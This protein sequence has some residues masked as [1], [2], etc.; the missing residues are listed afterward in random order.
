MT[1]ALNR[2]LIS[3]KGL[4]ATD[5]ESL[6]ERTEAYAGLPEDQAEFAA[7]NDLIAEATAERDEILGAIATQHADVVGKVSKKIDS[8]KAKQ[9]AE[10]KPD[11]SMIGDFGEKLEGA[12][13]DMAAEYKKHFSDDDIAKLPLSKIWPKQDIEKIED[14]FVAAVA[15]ATR[16]AVP[17]KPRTSYAVAAWVKKVKIA[18]SLAGMVLDGTVT[19]DNF[20]AKLAEIP[21]LKNFYSKVTLLESIDRAQWKRIGEVAE[22]P[23]A[24]WY[25][26]SNN[27]I[28]S[29]TV[30]VSIDGKSIS[31]KD[32]LSVADVI[33]KVNEALG[34]E[35]ED[36]KMQFE[37]RGR[38]GSYGINK[39]GDKEYRKLKTFAT[40]KEAFAFIKDNYTDLVAAW[41]GV[42][43]K[44]NVKKSD[45]RGATNRPRTGADHR[46]GKDVTAEEFQEAFGFRGGQF[47]NWVKQG[48]NAKDRQWMLNNAYDAL[49]DLAN[50]VG[51]P[52]KAISLNGSLGMSFGARG[53]GSASAHFEPGNLIINLTK[54]K[55]AGSLAHEWF[56]ALDN[57]FQRKRKDSVSFD[58]KNNFITYSPEA[59]YENPKGTRIPAK[60]F[61]AAKRG[62]KGLYVRNFDEWTKVEG[63]R[64]QVEA[65][66]DAL[67]K[68]LNDSPMTKR[69]AMIDAGK[70][71][72]YWSRIVERAARSFE[73][74]TIAKM[75]EQGYHNDYLA[76]VT[77]PARFARDMGRYPY[78]LP[79][80]IAPVSEAFDS[81]FG[82]METKETDKGV[83]LY[84]LKP[85]FAKGVSVQSVKEVAEPLLFGLRNAPKLE[86]VW[87]PADL[88]KHGI[89]APTGVRGVYNKGTLYIV[90]G[91]MSTPADVREVTFHEL[92]HFG[93]RGFFGKSLDKALDDIHAANPR[94]RMMATKWRR[95]NTDLIADLKTEHKL[96]DEDIHSISIDEALAEIAQTGETLK[97]W[98]KFVAALQ[99]LLRNVGLTRIANALESATDAEALLMLK[100]ADLYAKKGWTSKD[101]MPDAAYAMFQI[102]HAPPVFYSQ[103][104]R[105]IESHKIN[106]M[107]GKGWSDWLKSSS[108]QQMGVKKEEIE[109]TGINEWLSLQ[110]GK[111]TK[112]QI[113]AYL[114][115]GGVKVDEV[116][117]GEGDWAVYDGDSNQYFA[118]QSE[119]NA[120]AKEIGIN[121]TEDTVF[122]ATNRAGGYGTKFSSYVLPGGENYKELLLTLPDNYKSREQ[123]EQAASDYRKELKAKYGDIQLLRPDSPITA[124]E[125]AKLISLSDAIDNHL[126]SN[127]NFR[128]SHF[129]QPNIL[130]HIRMNER[131][132]AD[133]NK[134]LFIEEIQSDWGQK[135]KKEGFNSKVNL[136]AKEF[137]PGMFDIYEG[138]VVKNYQGPIEAK[139]SEEAIS[140]Y[141]ATAGTN[142]GHG[143]VPNAPFVTDTKSWTSLALKRAISYAVENGFQKIAWTTGEQQAA[144]YDLSKQVDALFYIKNGDGTFNIS[145]ER[146]NR[147]VLEE[148]NKTPSQL[149]EL[150]GKD[151][152]QKIVNDEGSGVED[153]KSISGAGL[154]VGGEG[155]KGF[156]DAIV[157][158]VAKKLGAEVGT[159]DLGSKLKR[160]IYVEKV[161]S[162]YILHDVING[163]YYNQ[164]Y[165]KPLWIDDKYSAMPFDSESEA[166]RVADKQQ[167]LPVE[168]PQPGF[169]ITD[170]MRE[171]VSRDGMPLFSRQ[172]T[173]GSV[174]DLK[175]STKFTDLIYKFQNKHIDLKDTIAAIKETGQEIRDTFNPYLQEELYH[176][177]VGKR[178]ED[179][180][181]NEFKP[182]L[183]QMRMNK[184]S[185]EDFEEYLHARH[186][187]EANK[188]IRDRDGMADGGS[189]MTDK[190]ADA[191]FAN[192][193]PA[194]QKTYES[195][196]AKVD[197]MIA[198]TRQTLVDYSLEDADTTKS[199]EQMFKHYVPLHREDMSEGQ[200]IGQGFSVKGKSTK[201][202]TGSSRQVADILANIA[203]QRDR[204]IVRGEKNRVATALY[205]LA[206]TNPNPD[207]WEADKVPT[208]QTVVKGKSTFDITYHGSVVRSVPTYAEAARFVKYDGRT[209]LQITEIKGKDHIESTSDP[210]Y[211]NR[212]NV[213]VARIRDSKGEVHDRAVVFNER[214][215]RALRMA[216]A[217]KNLD[218]PNLE[219]VI[220]LSAKVTRYLS[221]MSTQYNPVFV[222]VNFA[223]DFQNV[224]INLTSTP[225]AGKQLEVSKHAMSALIGIMA[226]LRAHRAGKTPNSVWAGLYEEMQLEGGTTGYREA[227]GTAKERTEDQIE[228]LLNPEWWAETGWGKALTV[229]GL[230]K[231]PEAWIV[232]KPGAYVMNMIS[233]LN[234]TAENAMRL[235]VY[236]VAI[237]QGMSKAQAASLSKNISVNFNR[238]GQVGAQMNAAYAFF[239]AAVQGTDRLAQTLK[240]PK[241]KQIIAG[242]IMIGVAQ[243]LAMM[244]AGLDDGEPPD[245][246]K[247]KSLIIPLG[248][249]KFLTI[250]MPLG[251][252]VLPGIGRISTELMLRGG[253]NPSK[254]AGDMISL[255]VG[256]FNPVGGGDL[257]S[258]ITPTPLDPVVD[259]ARNKDWTGKP[260]AKEDF[261]KNHPTPGHMRT[262]DTA[263]IFSKKL[264]EVLN[265]ISGGSDYTPGWA[266]PTPDQI[267][268]LITTATGGVGREISKATQTIE[269][270]T[271]GEDL[272]THKIPLVG[273]FYGEAKGQASEGGKFYDNLKEVNIA[274]AEVK[275]QRRDGKDPT[276]YIK[277]HPEARFAEAAKHAESRVGFLRR[278]KRRLLAEGADRQVIKAKEEQITQVMKRFNDRV[279]AAEEATQ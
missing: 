160:D 176:K 214:D 38:E 197:A 99:V 44:D 68:A 79:E 27:K 276:G 135:G 278:E 224:A 48:N 7:I 264:A 243:A 87:S 40:A 198:K 45:V 202:R 127:P 186:A 93:L 161:G 256:A 60:L 211:K 156:Y 121:I 162:T 134:V 14:V 12:R 107:P 123:Y 232:S 64:P 116:M 217:L 80:E 20:K 220:G 23:D 262:K 277:D 249:K 62:E 92:T 173:P 13:K 192:L 43:E 1:Q 150:V 26:D 128:S 75:A 115:Q 273:R 267:D 155:M 255:I 169:T 105:A 187:K 97:G 205:G 50:I 166:M 167:D 209:G 130:A 16:D 170:A 215:P 10:V 171:K 133:G 106:A 265:T 212:P 28:P 47:G 83:A 210:M 183:V 70:A 147:S 270:V 181:E 9:D 46:Q 25:D 201:S 113:A 225:L 230:L 279:R 141:R 222:A 244:A 240:G 3:T 272:P 242:G 42:K 159:V 168:K 223:R 228:K 52:P 36:K 118:N 188:L 91:A 51:I 67:V 193:D 24:Y 39:K 117:L 8:D 157:P 253:K 200:G 194:K 206:Y 114:D 120:Y 126:E 260:I 32:S 21:G 18:R 196:A 248:D 85:G 82:S 177:R 54:T 254:A 86:V 227:F 241:G 89:D 124:A 101:Y 163:K 19:K 231:A 158:Q 207:F 137:A 251:L 237:D 2:C 76:N 131:T 271:T 56:H 94:V 184:V 165:A 204:A 148:K 190:A 263:T 77:D 151:I 108:A 238:K 239:N 258:A 179:F 175:E 149:E 268:Y 95:Q 55:G 236:K 234:E 235:A 34:V 180:F 257:V 132:D 100:K 274:A 119:A 138:D 53:S 185:R 143:F 189:G 30:R 219:G 153:V 164:E 221:A 261:N 58:N 71:D 103:L 252:H 203:Q 195:L 74:Y 245:F 178:T 269:A 98:K 129:D 250:P 35:T 233:D 37:V 65:Q 5:K 140:K 216:E 125:R 69:A 88:A 41:D 229:G 152:A 191:Y 109:W 31:Y 122:R 266:S 154:K 110:Q 145:A 96:T 139:S 59:Y 275:G 81:L 17:T 146:E 112:E 84:S 111:V 102:G 6:R 174:F 72:G 11:Q 33:E 49:M 136:T 78:L 247:E 61:E 144:R 63:V 182:M 226:D 199:W 218:V 4:S 104:A 90:A 172:A 213:M 259:L 66:F 246:V 142:Q 73:N 57:Y 22:Y 29:P 15:Q 208:T